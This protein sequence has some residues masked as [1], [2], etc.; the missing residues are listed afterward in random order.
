MRRYDELVAEALARVR[1]IQ[2]WEPHDR[3]A[4]GNQPILLDVREREIVV[5]CRSGKRSALAADLLQLM[6]Y[7]RVASLKT[8]I[9]GWML[10]A[11]RWMPTARTRCSLRACARG[12]ASRERPDAGQVFFGVK[13]EPLNRMPAQ[14]VFMKLRM[15]GWSV[16]WGFFSTSSR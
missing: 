12:S 6:R 16:P 7:A 14:P 11:I 1:E 10:S 2:P 15:F 4:A 8:G 3:M 9:C 13:A 5:I